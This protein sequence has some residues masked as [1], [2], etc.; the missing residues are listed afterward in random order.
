MS[1][2]TL[3]ARSFC[4]LSSAS[5]TCQSKKNM[6]QIHNIKERSNRAVRELQ[7]AAHRWRKCVCD[8]GDGGKTPLLCADDCLWKTFCVKGHTRHAF[9]HVTQPPKVDSQPQWDQIEIELLPPPLDTSENWSHFL[10]PELVFIRCKQSKHEGNSKNLWSNKCPCT[11]RTTPLKDFIMVASQPGHG[12]HMGGKKNS[13][14]QSNYVVA[15]RLP[16]V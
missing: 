13:N 3:S 8:A 15:I 12:K 10:S 14:H 1:I 9:W 7:A 11:Y 2:Y 6:W 16:T 4:E 5:F